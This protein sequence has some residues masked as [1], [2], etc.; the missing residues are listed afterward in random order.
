MEVE[1]YE[2]VLVAQ[3]SP[4][5]G[6]NVHDGEVLTIVPR[7]TVPRKTTVPHDFVS[8]VKEV[9]P[10]T[11]DQ[12]LANHLKSS[13]I[14]ESQREHV[15]IMLSSIQKLPPETPATATYRSR[16]TIEQRMDLTVHKVIFFKA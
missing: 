16:G 2:K 4:K 10:F 11:L 6:C 7:T 14:S 15:R 1:F 5:N 3:Y 8:A 9:E 13:E 12:F